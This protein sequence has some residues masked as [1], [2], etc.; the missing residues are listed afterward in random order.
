LS[1]HAGA[2]LGSHARAENTG[3]DR[4]KGRDAIVFAAGGELPAD[5][6]AEDGAAALEASSERLA[7][8]S[9]QLP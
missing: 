3:L 1:A 4:R 5:G 8:P 6:S 9:A 2:Y 7:W